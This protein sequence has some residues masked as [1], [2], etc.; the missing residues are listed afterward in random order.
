MQC[1]WLILGM[2][3]APRADHLLRTLPPDLL[4][5]Y[6]RGHDDAVWQCLRELLG[7]PDDQDPQVAAV[8][9]LALLPARLG[10]LGLQ[11]AER[12]APAAYWA[13]WADALP[14]LRLHRPEAAARCHRCLAEL[15]AGPAS[16]ALCLR[17]VAAAGAHLTHAG[18]EGR[19]MWSAIHDGLRPAQCD[20][21]EP[22]ERC[23]GWQHHCS[24]ACSTRFRDTDCYRGIAAGPCAARA[25]A[26]DAFA[27]WA[28]RCRM[29]RHRP[30]RGRCNNAAR[31]HAYRFAAAVAPAAARRTRQ[32]WGPWTQLRRRGRC[33]R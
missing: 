1:A 31:P 28:A 7:E 33:L 32:M 24:R 26:A 16:F 13:A 8:R 18:W 11:C 4:A 2:C 27:V 29:A 12:V 22:G 6:A 17:A 30:Q 14:V 15:E 23:Q 19:P 3:A 20:L 10:G 25:G 5:S 21:P 9:H